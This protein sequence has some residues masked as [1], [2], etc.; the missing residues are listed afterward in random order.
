MMKVK[1]RE[2]EIGVAVAA[3]VRVEVVIIAGQA[4]ARSRVIAGERNFQLTKNF[5]KLKGRKVGKISRLFIIM[6]N[7]TLIIKIIYHWLKFH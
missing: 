1:E 6:I 5:Q 7:L 3:G 4:V 2:E